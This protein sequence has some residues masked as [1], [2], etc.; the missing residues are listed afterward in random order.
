MIK[1]PQTN[2]SREE[3]KK[4]NKKVIN[5]DEIRSEDKQV[6]TKTLMNDHN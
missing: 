3:R 1:Y 6:I 5:E 4:E 2:K